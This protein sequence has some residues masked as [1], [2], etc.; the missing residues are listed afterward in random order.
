MVGQAS[1]LI[2]VAYQLINTKDFLEL[3]TFDQHFP[4]NTHNAAAITEPTCMTWRYHWANKGVFN[5]SNQLSKFSKI[6][7]MWR[8]KTE[9]HDLQDR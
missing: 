4:N 6:W 7:K 9:F 3:R 5:L 8:D 1:L 2:E